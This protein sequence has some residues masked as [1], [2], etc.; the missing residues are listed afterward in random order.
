MNIEDNPFIINRKNKLIC[1][2]T[3]IFFIYR[4][5]LRCLLLMIT[6]ITIWACGFFIKNS[7]NF[8]LKVTTI[9]TRLVLYFC[10]YKNINIDE[11]SKKNLQ[12]TQS[13]IIFVNHSSYMDIMLIS[14]LFP[15][16][17]FVA[18]KFLKNMPFLKEYG[19][20]NCIFFSSTFGGN[21]I[22]TE[23]E[24]KLSE[25]KR[26]IFFSEGCCSRSDILLKLRKGAF[27]F[28]RSICPVHV[29]YENDLNWIMGSDNI[30]SHLIYQLSKPKNE[31]KIKVL[32]DYNP[33]EEEKNNIDLFI[34]NFREYY[35]KNTGIKMSNLSYANHPFYERKF[36]VEKKQKEEI[37]VE[38]EE[39]KLERE[40][41]RV[42]KEEVKVE[43]N[44][45]E[46]VEEESDNKVIKSEYLE[47]SA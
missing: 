36:K 47:I 13:K 8:R 16:A 5:I 17:V 34:E 45:T 6:T 22:L 21:N 39:V 23:I 15:D 43:K 25:G 24:K 31:L 7:E 46:N 26:I 1:L 4:G 40:E 19:K 44:K 9:L 27:T 32:N 30:M 3:V 33:N 20:Y 10:G 28:G 37:K 41:I 11:D 18:S 38:K 29:S 14:Y 12:N 2:K 42:E 35:V